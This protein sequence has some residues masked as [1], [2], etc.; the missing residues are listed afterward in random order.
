MTERMG[1]KEGPGPVLVGHLPQ[2]ASRRRQS[3]NLND[4]TFLSP[5]PAQ[6]SGHAG[7][8]CRLH[9]NRPPWCLTFLVKGE[10]MRADGRTVTERDLVMSLEGEVFEPQGCCGQECS[11][12]PGTI[13]KC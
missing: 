6:G 10:K 2:A 9:F 5:V 12:H 1:W 8:D 13:L 11:S 3:P 4:Q 7:V